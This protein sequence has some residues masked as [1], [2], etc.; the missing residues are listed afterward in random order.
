[1]RELPLSV[2]KAR[3][4]RRQ[5]AEV[6]GRVLP[7]RRSAACAVSITSRASSRK[8]SRISSSCSRLA[9]QGDR[10]D[11]RA[12]APAS[13][14]GVEPDRLGRPWRRSR[15]APRR[16][17]RAR[18]AHARRVVAPLPMR[19]LRLQHGGGERRLVG[20]LRLV[21][22]ALELARHLLQRHVLAHRAEG[23]HL[24]LLDQARLDRRAAQRAGPVGGALRPIT[25]A[26]VPVAASKTNSDFAICGCTLSMSIRKPSAAR[27]PARRS[28]TPAARHACR[29]DL[30]R[31]QAVDLVAHAQQ[32]L[33]G[34]V[35]AE[36]RQ[37]AAHRRELHRH[38]RRRT[39]RSSGLRKNW[40][41]AFSASVSEAR[42]SCTTL[43]IVCRSETRR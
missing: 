26:S 3:R 13:L 38:R 7:A 29:I 39:P 28:N 20:G 16:A 5:H 8:M 24:R 19:L 11:R 21:R 15:P 42:S 9:D 4:T 33:R 10:L 6:A 30:G 41:I 18:V 31:D 2:W 35:H 40:S 23:E 14:I 25:G 43:P 17:R 22:Q 1:M 36:H 32:R 12:A 34:L 27:L 37:H